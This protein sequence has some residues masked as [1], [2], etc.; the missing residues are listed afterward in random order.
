MR[1]LQENGKRSVHDASF[2]GQ[3]KRKWAS[4]LEG[5]KGPH[6]AGVT[7]LLLETELEYLDGM[8]EETQAS[9]AGSFVKYVF[10]VLRRVFPNLIAHEILTVQPMTAPVGAVFTY[11]YQHANAKGSVSANDNL[12][13]TFD[14][15]YSSEKVPEEQPTGWTGD[16]SEDTFSGTLEWTPVRGLDAD[17][18][19]SVTVTDGTETFTDDGAGALTGDA[20]GSGT[21][22]YTTGAIEVTFDAAPD[23]DQDITVTYWYNSESNT[24]VPEVNIALSMTEVRAETR[25]LK[26]V[27]SAEA[28][29]DLKAFHG[30]EAE[31]ELVAGIAN[32]VALEIDRTMIEMIKTGAGSTSSWAY[33]KPTGAVGELDAIRNLLTILSARSAKIY[34]DTKRAPANFIVSTPEVVGLMEQLTTHGDYRPIF[35]SNPDDPYGPVDPQNPG[36]YGPLTSQF[37]VMRAGTLMNKWAIYQDPFL[38]AATA[39]KAAIMGLKGR[40]F[41]DAGAYYAPYIPLQMTPTFLDPDSQDYKKGMRT[42][43]ASG[44]LRSEYY[45]DISITGLPT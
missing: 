15:W 19:W 4:L 3:L 29:D 1:F 2:V 8:T 25:K 34:V 13:E 39:T 21:V 7:A 32:E 37:G 42:R 20:G 22:N 43:Y 33:A 28:A 40:S 10:P 36:S 41:M 26:A 17:N 16:G 5:V 24:D 6:K 27:W 31:T 18:G 12:I 45:C 9:G 44:V 30:I 38:T 35:T 14:N 23:A 11:E